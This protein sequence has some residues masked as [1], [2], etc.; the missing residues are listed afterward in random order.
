MK[1]TLQNR[2]ED[3]LNRTGLHWSIEKG[4]RHHHIRLAGHL[5]G[6]LP[7]GCGS[8]SGYA[9]KNVIAQIKRTAR[10]VRS[11]RRI[12]RGGVA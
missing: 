1:A 2:V 8:D 3:E 6:I 9:L 11:E 10:F 4:K 5:V 7:R 12:I